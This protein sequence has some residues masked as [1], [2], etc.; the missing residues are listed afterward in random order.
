MWVKAKQEFIVIFIFLLLVNMQYFFPQFS[1]ANEQIR[2]PRFAGS[3]YPAEAD[4]LEKML[5]NYL[6]AASS[7]LSSQPPNEQIGK[8]VLAIIAPHAGYMYSGQTAAF[9]YATLSGSRYKR[10]FLLGP[11]HHVP[12]AGAVLPSQS[13]FETPLGKIEIDQATVN[14]LLKLPGFQQVDQVFDIEHSLEMQLPWICKTL[15]K[16]KLVPMAIGNVNRETIAEIASAIKK[17]LCPGDLIIV[18]SDFTHYGPRFDYQPFND[19]TTDSGLK[20]RIAEL[21]KEAFNHLKKL[22]GSELLEFYQRSHDTICGI[23]PCAI[24]LSLL[25]ADAQAK[26]LNYRTSADIEPDPQGNSVSY[27]SIAFSAP[28]LTTHKKAESTK[29]KKYKP[30]SLADGQ[31]LLKIARQTLQ[32]YLSGNRK[33]SSQYEKLLSQHQIDRFKEEHG[34]FVTLYEK[35]QQPISTQHSNSHPA[36]QLRGCI[37]YIYPNKPLL[38]G[39]CENAIN[40]ACADPRFTPVT[41]DELHNLD[42]EINILTKPI[43]VSSWQDIKL[44]QDGIVLKKGGRQAVFL[45]KVATEFG[46]DLPQTLTQLSLKAGLAPDDWRD[47]A[48]FEVFQSE[49]FN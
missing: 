48:Q 41:A 16:A 37:G 6:Q 30:L 18:S 20:K 10:V 5:T 17:E 47:G 13:I 36:K 25:P 14:K 45:P 29:E 3:W 28:G 46:W 42:L 26:L 9:A 33:D 22:D 2:S 19:E 38:T 11:S 24:L 27:M 39:V 44:G 21:D 12:F 1:K 7:Q 40:A 4:V 23:Y 34:V 32:D 31:A 49:I 8:N 35:P 15:N 43:P